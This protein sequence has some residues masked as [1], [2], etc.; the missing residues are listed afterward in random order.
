MLGG[1]REPG[2]VEGK[3]ERAVR[4]VVMG[5]TGSGKSTIGRI[6]ATRLGAPFVDA[7]D[8]HSAAAKAAM[9]AGRPLDDAE[10]APWLRRVRTAVQGAG[11]GPVVLACSALKRSYRDVLR[12]GV[13]GLSFVDLD[14]DA[15]TLA[16]RLA[17]RTGHFAGPALLPSQLATLELGDDVARVDGR[18]APDVVADRVLR[19]AGGACSGQLPGDPPA[20]NPG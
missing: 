7:D 4:V 18:G 3:G 20:A 10:R 14:V 16:A 15:D 11:D 17:T 1:A 8:L 2:A 6:V 9:H 5:V 13:P 12:D 19:A